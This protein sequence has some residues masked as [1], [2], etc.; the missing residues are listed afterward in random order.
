MESTVRKF[1]KTDPKEH[2]RSSVTIHTKILNRTGKIG[3]SQTPQ[4]Q[5]LTEGTTHDQQSQ[6]STGAVSIG[7]SATRDDQHEDSKNQ[8][9]RKHK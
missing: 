3:S 6:S 8:N 5:S 4:Q 7:L 2:K 9:T 1:A